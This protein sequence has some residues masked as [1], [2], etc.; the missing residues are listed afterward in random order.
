MVSLRVKSQDR[1]TV[2]SRTSGRVDSQ[3]VRD[4]EYPI[5]PYAK[6]SSLLAQERAGS[7]LADDDDEVTTTRQF[8]V[9]QSLEQS[10]DNVVAVTLLTVL[11]PSRSV[12]AT[13]GN[14]VVEE[15]NEWKGNARSVRC[16][17]EGRRGRRGIGGAV[18]RD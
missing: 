12:A 8:L 18:A 4:A 17:A 11:L 10:G 14:W 6:E 13:A 7:R 5:P 16:V 3:A 1:K 2:V 15:E 9:C